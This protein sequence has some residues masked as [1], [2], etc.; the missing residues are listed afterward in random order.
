MKP[1]AQLMAKKAQPRQAGMGGLGDG[2]LPVKMKYRLGAAP[3]LR[4]ATPTR[5]AAPGGA[6]AMEAV[7]DE[8]NVHVFAV[9]RPILVKVVE[10]SRPVGRESVSLVITKGK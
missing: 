4:K 8:I 6:L 1:R 9:R 7:A 10:K 2:T 5:I 3:F